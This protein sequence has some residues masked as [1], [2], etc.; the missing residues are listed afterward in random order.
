M[1]TPW[2]VDRHA[3]AV[4][5]AVTHAVW[6]EARVGDTCTLAYRRRVLIKMGLAHLPLVYGGSHSLVD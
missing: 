6:A 2:T 5:V 3:G 4:E 1:W